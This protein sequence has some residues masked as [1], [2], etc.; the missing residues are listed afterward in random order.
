MRIWGVSEST[1]EVDHLILA[2]LGLVFLDAC[3]GGLG[4]ILVT[5]RDNAVRNYS[6][7]RCRFVYIVSC[8]LL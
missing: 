2:S 8:R 3:V 1:S 4:M 7:Y 5:L 6:L